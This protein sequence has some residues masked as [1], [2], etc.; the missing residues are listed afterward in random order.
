MGI[1]T[2]PG[3]GKA[4]LNVLQSQVLSRATAVHLESWPTPGDH[5]KE[6]A[7]ARDERVHIQIS[8]IAAETPVSLTPTTISLSELLQGLPANGMGQ[9][10]GTLSCFLAG[11]LCTHVAGVKDPVTELF[12]VFRD[13]GAV[14]LLPTDAASICNNLVVCVK[15]IISYLSRRLAAVQRPTPLLTSLDDFAAHGIGDDSS[16]AAVDATA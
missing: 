10:L 6:I 11:V 3:E 14:F 8:V 2:K 5:R 1:A 16:R 4:H 7:D 12:G 15:Q 13:V 9:V